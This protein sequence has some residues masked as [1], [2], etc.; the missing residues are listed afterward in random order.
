LR[1]DGLF[2]EPQPS[3][4]RAIAAAAGCGVGGQMAG[5]GDRRVVAGRARPIIFM[6]PVLPDRWYD[7]FMRRATGVPS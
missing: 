1:L 5:D 2:G 3:A 7:A 4:K 6:H